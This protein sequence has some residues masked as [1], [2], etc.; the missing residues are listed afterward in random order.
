MSNLPT[1]DSPPNS[2]P[3]DSLVPNTL[4]PDSPALD[5]LALDP[6]TSDTAPDPDRRSGFS[7]WI[8]G[9]V[10]LVVLGGG[11]WAWRL[12]GTPPA[13]EMQMPPGVAVTVAPVE[14]GTVQESSEFLGRLEALAGVLLQPEVSGRVTQVFVVAGDRVSPGA[15]IVQ[16]SPDRTEAELNAAAA[17][18]AA[19]RAAQD[20]ALASLQV[21]RAQKAEQEADLALAQADFERTESLVSQGAQ[22]QRELDLAR[23]DRDV[24]KASLN[25]ALKEIAVAQ[26][27]LAQAEASL[28]Q[29]SANQAAVAQDVKDRTVTA[30]IAGIVGDLKI[31]LGDYVNPSTVITTITEN[32]TLL[33]KIPVP[34]EQRDRLRLGLRVDVLAMGT[35]EVLTTGRVSFIAP[36]TNPDTQ[37]VLVQAQ[38]D[39][40]QGRFQD[41]QQVEA[42]ITWSEEVGVLVPTAAI[43]RLGGQ[44]FVYIA[45]TAD[46]AELPPDA[47]A[48]VARLRPVEL[49][50]VQGNRYEV[51][52]GVAQGE[53]IVVSGILNLQDGMPILP[54]ESGNQEAGKQEAGSGSPGTAP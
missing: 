41:D 2:P 50:Q 43:A 53:T 40:A 28:R 20:T 49:G 30:P 15:A 46:P 51:V 34:V 21:L 7:R 27:Q 26:S 19:A 9:G 45:E 44:T 52:S 12:L 42:R 35:A 31:K 8:V 36:Q 5:S 10:G 13:A 47:P 22:S 37:T 1:N 3:S 32:S 33:L 39:N 23:R 18:V 11:F 48:Q 4:A 38:L 29:A 17:T 16:V 24:A 25:S 6:P 54:Q 14:S